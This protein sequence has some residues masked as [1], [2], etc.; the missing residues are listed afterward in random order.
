MGVDTLN[1]LVAILAVVAAAPVVAEVLSRWVPVPTIVVEIVG[2]I[3]IGPAFGW[4]HYNEFVWSL[5]DLGLAMLMF[6][7]GMEIDIPR[8]SGRPLNRA[9]GGW[10][11]RSCWGWRPATPWPR[12]AGPTA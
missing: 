4:V 7:V 1:P 8:V 11:C 12:S 2:G 9:L 5:S 6:L 10:A 3:L